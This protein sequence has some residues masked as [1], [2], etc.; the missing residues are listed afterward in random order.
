MTS[1]RPSSPPRFRLQDA[2][3]KLRG[4]ANFAVK[5]GDGFHCSEA[6]AEMKNKTLRVLDLMMEFVRNAIDDA[7]DAE[8]L[9]LNTA[10]SDY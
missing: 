7:T 2:P 5:F 4:L 6:I 9:C 10:A 3:P 1:R 8:Q